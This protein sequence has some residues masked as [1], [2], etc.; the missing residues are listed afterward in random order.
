VLAAFTLGGASRTAAA[1][2]HV[3]VNQVGYVATQAKRAYLLA[4]AAE[5]GAMFQVRRT[6]DDRIVFSGRVGRSVGSWS[7]AF[8]NVYRLDFDGLRSPGTY[9]IVVDGPLDAASP[10]FAVDTAGRLFGGLVANARFFFEAQRDGDRVIERVLDRQ[11]SHLNDARAQTYSPPVYVDEVLQADLSPLGAR[12]DASGGWFDAGDYLKFVQTHSYVLDL[13]LVGLRDFPRQMGTDAPSNADFT[14]EARFGLEW[15][16]KMWDDRTRTLYY[17]VGIGAGDDCDKICGDHDIWR[18][19][20]ADDDWEAG[21]PVFRYVRH[22]PVFRAGA[23]GARISPNLAGR[24]AA[25]FALG[26]QVFKDSDRDFAEK[27]L[28]AAEHVYD[29]AD[30]AP[31]GELLSVSPHDFYPESTWR[32]D[33]E[34]GATELS[35]ALT[36]GDLPSHLEHRDPRFY[37]RRAAHWAQAWIASGEA[38][39]DTLNLY[40]VSALAHYDLF[41]AINR[42]G[43]PSGLEISKREL[44]DA[45]KHQLDNASEQAGEDPFGSGFAWN[46]FDVTTHLFG[47]AISAS[48]YDELSG[49]STYASFGTRQLAAA[50]GANAWGMSFIVGAGTTFPHCMQHQVANL[51]GSL[52]GRRPLVL[53]ATVNGSNSL[54]VFDES[55]TET[56]DGARACPA[57]GSDF[58]SRFTGRDA[59]VLDNVGAWM[60]VEPAIDFTCAV[61]LA[62]SRY[63]AGRF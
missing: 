21:D 47:L 24:L 61:P 8:P 43:Q 52:D 18:L 13:L 50:L 33:L 30:T 26:F 25:A 38:D 49:T 2:A 31:S 63:I 54:D 5:D 44:L 41:R 15:L 1:T 14:R 32:D 51:S 59:R 57:D 46:Q 37:L 45:I 19:P 55:A 11:P 20:E 40:D 22:R 28:I 36:S 58:F 34:L 60:S 3:R 10:R 12:R 7:D 48:L 16:H 4:G 27:C 39:D 62:L 42:T 23:P 56:P 6:S 17:Q 29:L 53:G 9:R 35:L